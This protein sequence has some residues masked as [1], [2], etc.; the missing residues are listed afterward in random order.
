ML[1][2][3]PDGKTL[4]SKTFNDPAVT[5]SDPE[6]GKAVRRLGDAAPVPGNQ[7]FIG[8]F[9]ATNGRDFAFSPDGKLVAVGGAGVVRLWNTAT[10]KEVA[11]NSGHRGPVTS[12]VIS[13]D[14]KLIAS[15]GTDQTIRLWEAATG[16]ELNHFPLPAGTTTI[17]F[18][19]DGRRVA[20]GNVDTSIRLVD[21]T[22]GK[23]VHKLTGHQNGVASVAFSPDGKTVASRFDNTILF[24]DAATGANLRR[25]VINPQN[26]AN[27]PNGAFIVRMGG[28]GMAGNGLV[29]SPDN[30]TVAAIVTG[31]NFV[32]GRGVMNAVNSIHVWEV[33]TGK[34]VGKIELPNQFGTLSFTFGPDGRTIAT[35]NN[36]Q[37]ITVWEMASSRERPGSANRS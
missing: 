19:A 1:V 21:T 32:Q 28:Y 27:N 3:S 17:A 13:P 7:V 29:F 16:K 15:K 11:H 2:F 22:T 30:K 33:A 23:E 10:G 24:H 34:E 12:A 4:A 31:N 25:V 5:L 37:T 18:A 20:L 35:E 9:G 14:G 6:T 26:N 36:D 8:G